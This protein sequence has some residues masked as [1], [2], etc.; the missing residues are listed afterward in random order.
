LSVRDLLAL[1]TRLPVGSGSVEGAASSFYLVPLVGLVEGAIVSLVGVAIS[2]LRLQLLAA[3]L[4]IAAHLAVTGGMHIEGLADYSDVL[5][6][7]LRGE[8]ALK[9]LKDP[10]RGS[11]AVVAVV[12]ALLV[13]F[14]AL[15]YLAASPVII[16][17]SYISSL[18]ASFIVARLGVEEP[19]EG[20]ARPFTR[21]A[22]LAE[23]LRLN[24]IVYVALMA[25]LA[26][27]D[28]VSL[29]TALSLAAGLLVALDANS[30]LGFVN[31]DVI[32]TSIELGGLVALVAG[33]LA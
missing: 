7:G 17:A 1:F 29:V 33:A 32:G 22:K 19:Y 31:G 12:V 9:V 13:R 10:R 27:F 18:E 2:Y 5:G 30:R 14:S 4:M 6:S 8:G 20:M 3:A 23:Q 21:S 28:P 25:A 26:L 24:I 15:Y 16:M 11:F